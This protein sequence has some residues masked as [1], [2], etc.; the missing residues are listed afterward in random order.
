MLVAHRPSLNSRDVVSF[1]SG[2]AFKKGTPLEV[3]VEG[4]EASRFKLFTERGTA[5]CSDT[6]MDQKLTQNLLK[7]NKISVLGQSE[8]GLKTKDVYSLKGSKAAYMVVSKACGI[9]KG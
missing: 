5:W 3:T 9:G 6:A 2:Y 1:D 8:K 7:G 4:A